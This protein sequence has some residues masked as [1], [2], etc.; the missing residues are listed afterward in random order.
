MKNC[1]LATI[2]VGEIQ[3]GGFAASRDV[4]QHGRYVVSVE[5]LGN[6]VSLTVDFGFDCSYLVSGGSSGGRQQSFRLLTRRS[7]RGTASIQGF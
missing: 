2:D 1:L 5:E 7:R 3:V 6:L 4:R